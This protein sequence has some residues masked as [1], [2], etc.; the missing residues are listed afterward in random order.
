MLR[1]PIIAVVFITILSSVAAAQEPA[2]L[3]IDGAEHAVACHFRGAGL[4]VGEGARN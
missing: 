2:L 4:A 1:K 3:Q